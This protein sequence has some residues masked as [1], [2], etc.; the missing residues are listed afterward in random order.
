MVRLYFT[1]RFL[2]IIV[3]TIAGAVVYILSLTGMALSVVWM[4]IDRS[5][6]VIADNWV[7][8]M[9]E[10]GFPTIWTPHL[11]Y[12]VKAVAFFMMLIAWILLAHLMVFIVKLIF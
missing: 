1:I 5:S 9:T 3:P 2:Q 7:D 4:T 6:S 8:R 10:R 11:Y 12:S